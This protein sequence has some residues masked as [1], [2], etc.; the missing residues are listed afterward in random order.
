MQGEARVDHTA[1]REANGGEEQ[2]HRKKKRDKKAREARSTAGHDRRD[3]WERVRARPLHGTL[4]FRTPPL[5]TCLA[6]ELCSSQNPPLKARE[7]MH[8]LLYMNMSNGTKSLFEHMGQRA[9]LV[10]VTRL[11]LGASWLP[12]IT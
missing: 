12:E 9:H 2:P 5:Y 7:T 8:M 11:S 6:W 1:G 3:I 4:R 10:R